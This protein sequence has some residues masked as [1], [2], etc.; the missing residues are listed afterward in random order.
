MLIQ[1]NNML[2]DYLRTNKNSHANLKAALQEVTGE[3]L[4]IGPYTAPRQQARQDPL[5]VLRN[6][7]VEVQEV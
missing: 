1:G 4:G 7:G 5:E 3:E 2:Y 6:Q